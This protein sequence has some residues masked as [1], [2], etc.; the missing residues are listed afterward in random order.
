MVSLMNDPPSA[1]AD[2]TPEQIALG[3]R[4]VEAWRLAGAELSRLRRQ[5]LRELDTYRGIALLLRCRRLHPTSVRP[6]TQFGLGRTA[7]L[8][9]EGCWA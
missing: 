7:A 3:K 1:L 8:V 9:Y 2:W 5:E 6:E 4:W